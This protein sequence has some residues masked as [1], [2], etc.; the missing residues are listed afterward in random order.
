[1]ALSAVARSRLR[2]VLEAIRQQGE[3]EVTA[4]FGG[5]RTLRATLLQ[6]LLPAACELMDEVIPYIADTDSDDDE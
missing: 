2:V 1:M 3:H 4:G 6:P 5:G